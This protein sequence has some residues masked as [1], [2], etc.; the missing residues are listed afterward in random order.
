MQGYQAPAGAPAFCTRLATMT[1]L[2]QLPVSIGT[3]AAGTDVE[4]RT[5]VAAL[6]RELRGVLSAVRSEGGSDDLAAALD[7]L[8]RALGQV[9]DGP[10][11]DPVLAGVTAG[12][13]QVAVQAQPVCGFPT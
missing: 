5:Q 6:M 11:P 8:V 9:A 7:G 4:A 3:L 1:E 2:D 10:L 12:L 13:E